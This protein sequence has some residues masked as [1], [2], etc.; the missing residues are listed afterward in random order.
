M[1]LR[2][3][4]QSY[5]LE[6]V[7]H[8]LEAT[9]DHHTNLQDQLGQYTG[10]FWKGSD[11]RGDYAASNT[12]YE[13]L[14]L[15]VPRLIYDNPR[16]NVGTR[17]PGPVA[18]VAEAIGHGLNRL[19]RDLQ[20]RRLLAEVAADMMFTYGVVVTSEVAR[21]GLSL[22]KDDPDFEGTPTWPIVS[23]IPPIKFFMDI[24]ATRREDCR[25]FGHESSMDKAGLLRYAK[26]HPEDG[27][28]VDVIGYLAEDDD[29]QFH[30]QRGYSIPSRGQIR[31]YQAWVPEIELPDSPGPEKGFHGTI[32]TL[33]KGESTTSPGDY[34]SLLNEKGE[35][36]RTGPKADFL[37][38]PR[39]YY[40]PRWGPYTV[41]GCYN[42]PDSPFPL[43]PLT[44]CEAQ[45]HELNT[46]VKAASRSMAKHKR[47]IF[48]EDHKTADQV[49]S[50]H[51]DYVVVAPYGAD[52][53]PRVTQMDFAGLSDDQTE[54]IFASMDRLDR[55]LGID[56]ALRGNVEGRGTATEHAIASESSTTRISF[57]KQQFASATEQV[58]RTMAF[59]MY[60]SDSIVFPMG[61]DLAEDGFDMEEPWFQGGNL[62]PESGYSFDDLELE[63]DP[64]SLERS[65]EGLKQRRAQEFGTQML[66]SIELMAT[67]PSFPWKDFW[68]W[69]ADSQ[70]VQSIDK[71]F[72][73]EMLQQL[74]ADLA[75][76]ESISAQNR[77]S[78]DVGKA[79]MPQTS[80][81]APFNQELPSNQGQE[82]SMLGIGM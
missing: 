55:T 23:R 11:R 1:T 28:N 49:K 38:P 70:N 79:G 42:V 62:D 81:G 71:F 78:K 76:R 68:K 73:E 9:K 30:E 17:R 29:E 69:Q 25:F 53:K 36:Y 3:H 8:A 2:F 14:S 40:G 18:E 26:D 24:G 44:A 58:L 37:R 63:I 59:Y 7:E 52:G 21:E 32:F 12:Y 46:H 20:L 39:P 65:D 10:P 75:N 74:G 31:I 51:H 41:Y 43:G 64:Y 33:G 50:Q 35:P 77:T 45:I 5:M 34:P 61:A 27:W 16:V 67:F 82:A 22:P 66:S 47:L 4:D 48:C 72:P 56:D 19:V 80:G 57:I 6:E 13:Y 54:W 15:L 60:H